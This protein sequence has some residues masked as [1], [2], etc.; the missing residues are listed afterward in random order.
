MDSETGAVY[1]T[2]VGEAP[3]RVFVVEWFNRPHYSNTGSGT[4]ELLL[5]ETTNNIKFQ[6]QDVDFGSASYNWGVSA[7]AGIRQAG[8]NY[9][10][11]SYNQAVL[12]NDLAICFNHPGSPPCDGGDVAW[13]GEDP[14]SGTVPA[15]STLDVTMLFT[16]TEAVSITLPGVYEANL[17]VAGDPHL[18]VPVVMT[19]IEEEPIT[20]LAATND[21]PTLLGE[22]T[23]FTATV[24]GGTSILYT[25]D[26]G[27]GATASGAVVTHVYATAG[28]FT[29]TV[30][31]TNSLG[32]VEAET[33]AVIVPP[34]FYTFLP[35]IF[36]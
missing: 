36:K 19:V 26:F 22:T 24:T 3:N 25:W 28:S 9:L 16:A 30:T 7:T 31:A 18:V 11:Y 29:A 35:L 33:T 34:R 13:L 2:T 5:Y 32:S 15:G 6:Y 21:S 1:Y 23:T 27:D 10:Q 17:I 20:G 8:A 14:V 4:F 12:M